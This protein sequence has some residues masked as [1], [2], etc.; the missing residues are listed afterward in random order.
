MTKQTQALLDDVMSKR[1]LSLRA[2][3]DV[4]TSIKREHALHGRHA[5]THAWA[6]P[7]PWE[8]CTARALPHARTHA[9]TSTNGRTPMTRART[10]TK[11]VLQEATA[12]GQTT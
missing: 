11:Y 6:P 10:H 12:R 9:H 8:A 7:R 4:S 3:Q 5:H 1:G 2:M